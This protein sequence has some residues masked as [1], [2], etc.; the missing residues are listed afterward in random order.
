MPKTIY[1]TVTLPASAEKLFDMYLDPELHSAF[2]GAPVTIS[3]T[4]G[5]EFRAFDNMLT[6]KILYV[7]PKRVIVQTWRGKDWKPEDIDSILVL[8]FL[9]GGTSGRIELTHVN[10]PDHDYEDV[11]QGWEKYYW[12]PWREYLEKEMRRA[13]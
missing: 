3:P 13:A 8:T 4:P 6:G 9:P 5:S 12:K 7:V 11:N 1:Q 10:V 2:T